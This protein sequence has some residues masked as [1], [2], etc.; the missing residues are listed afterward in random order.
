MRARSEHSSIVGIDAICQENARCRRNSVTS[1]RRHRN[2]YI[3]L[4][5]QRARPQYGTCKDAVTHEWSW[6]AYL[7]RCQKTASERLRYQ[8]VKG[9]DIYMCGCGRRLL[10]KEIGGKSGGSGGKAKHW[11]STGS[12]LPWSCGINQS[13]KSAVLHTL[14]QMGQPRWFRT[15]HYWWRIL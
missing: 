2:D 10:V 12:L 11:G 13:S 6:M 4:L 9:V 7:S 15:R 8:N 1:R 5:R 14:L 3:H